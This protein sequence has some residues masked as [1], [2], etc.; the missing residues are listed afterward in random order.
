MGAR[1]IM[2]WRSWAAY[3]LVA[4]L[5]AGLALGVPGVGQAQDGDDAASQGAQELEADEAELRAFAQAA[6]DILDIA[7]DWEERLEEAENS[8]ARQELENEYIRERIEIVEGYDLSVERYNEIYNAV[9]ADPEFRERINA[10]MR[11]Y[12]E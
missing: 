9:Q 4:A 10:L 12:V 3:T 8:E 7:P 2:S 1:A 11:E 6:L 5:G